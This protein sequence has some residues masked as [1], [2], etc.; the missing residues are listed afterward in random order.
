MEL[1]LLLVVLIVLPVV[2][3]ASL[4]VIAG[5]AF[6]YGALVY[7]NG[8]ERDGRWSSS[9][10]RQTLPIWRWLR[11]LYRFRVVGEMPVGPVLYAHHPHGMLATSATL[12]YADMPRTHLAVHSNFFR[13]PLLL[14]EP[15]LLFGAVDA[16][17]EV[18]GLQLA[19]QKSVALLPGGVREQV[20]VAKEELRTNFLQWSYHAWQTPIVPVWAPAELDVCWVWKPAALA[21]LRAW[22]MRQRWLRYP[23]GTFFCP[24][25]WWMVPP[26]VVHVGAP[27]DPRGYESFDAFTRAFEAAVEDLKRRAAALT[28]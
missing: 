15:L 3:F 25:P 22:G 24:K 23:L 7:T 20:A 6:A 11:R 17:P 19:R 14:R 26:L 9:F 8:A 1:I 27:V 28:L 13:I 18:I 4:V 21:S 16:D 12:F 10:V 2:L 5:A